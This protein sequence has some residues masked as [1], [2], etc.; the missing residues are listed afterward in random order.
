MMERM[1]DRSMKFILVREVRTIV[2]R[3]VLDWLDRYL[4]RP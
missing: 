3:E 2:V 1:T 4:G